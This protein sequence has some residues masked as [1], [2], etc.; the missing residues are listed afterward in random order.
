M[1][2]CCYWCLKWGEN[3]LAMFLFLW[4][5]MLGTNNLNPP[6]VCVPSEP[7]LSGYSDFCS[8]VH[9]Q[10]DGTEQCMYSLLGW[11]FDQ[12]HF[13]FSGNQKWECITFWNTQVIRVCSKLNKVSVGP[14][15]IFNKYVMEDEN[16]FKG[17]VKFKTLIVFTHLSVMYSSS[18]G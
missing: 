17:N 6:F 2:V 4:R 5:Q 11:V 15:W 8:V 14:W 1:H 18:K 7:K 10:E 13:W 16:I 12:E 3:Y 9:S